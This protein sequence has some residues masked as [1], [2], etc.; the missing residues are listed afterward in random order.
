MRDRMTR[1]ADAVGHQVP[2]ATAMAVLLLVVLAAAAL[3]LGN[4]VEATTDAFY[5]GLWML[6]AFSMQMALLLVL[7]SVL[8]AT[9]FFR[10]LVL[11]LARLPASRLAR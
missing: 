6:L 4:G 5:R 9:P 2:D 10:T 7:S 11:R 8:S 1:F 3:G